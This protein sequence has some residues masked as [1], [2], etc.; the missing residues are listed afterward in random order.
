MTE[1]HP[2]GPAA[3]TRVVSVRRVIPASP[4]AIFA[5]I[6][7]PAKHRAFDGSGSL[8]G[9]SRSDG[10]LHMGSRFG[11][12]MKIGVPYRMTNEVVEF[13][14]GRHI[15]WRHTGHHVWRYIL[16]PAPDG[17][18][19]TVTEQFDWRSSRAPWFLTLIGAPER[20]RRSMETSLEQLE[21]LA[22]GP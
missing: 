2:A 20:N 5:I 4:E 16:E 12:R 3:V 1:A 10:R 15:A 14:E 11:M 13:E 22:T 7:D 9:P 6:A 21:A 8:R 17:T 18:S 19:T